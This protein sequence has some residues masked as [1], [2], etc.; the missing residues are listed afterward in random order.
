M[1]KRKMKK[2]MKRFGAFVKKANAN[3]F[4]VS[5]DGHDVISVPVT[6]LAV[7]VLFF[8]WVTIPLVVIGLFCGCRYRFQGPD[9]GIDS[10]NSIM[11]HAAETAVSIKNAVM[12]ED[13]TDGL[14]K[15]MAYD[16][17]FDEDDEDD[18]DLF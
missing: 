16:D 12:E 18:D 15:D 2:L 3:Q 11:D 5:K 17:A 6:L 1:H 7:A 14:D 10:I 13:G 4:V 8:F 9:L